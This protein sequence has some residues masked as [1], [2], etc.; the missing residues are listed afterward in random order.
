[1]PAL[2]SH[3]GDAAKSALFRKKMAKGDPNA[4]HIIQWIV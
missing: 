4:T 1:M 2:V 3:P